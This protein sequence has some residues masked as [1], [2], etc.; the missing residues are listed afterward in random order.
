M[1]KLLSIAAMAMGLATPSLAQD[2]EIRFTLDWKLQGVHAWFYLA[3]EKGYFAEE[4]L[5]VT[6]DQGEGSAA[7]ITRI[8]SGAYD[9][10]F[11]DMNAIVQNA[12]VT[13]ELA[14]IMVY[15]IYNQPPF[16]ILVPADSP[17]EGAADLAGMTV[18]SPPGSAVT[19]LFPA[20]AA[21]AGLDLEEVDILSV[22]PNLQEQML[23]QGDVDASL[24]F[25][26]TSYLNLIGLGK[27]PD[28]EYRFIGYGD[29]GLDIYSNGVMVSRQLYEENPEAVAGLVRAINRAVMEIIADPA[30]GGATVKGVEPLIDEDLE[31]MRLNFA[32]ENLITSE[33]SLALGV[34]GVDMDRLARTIGIIQSVYEFETAPDASTIFTDEFLPP[35]EDRAL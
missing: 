30:L 5:S 7:T 26:V 33:E 22:Q 23:L 16:S 11:G 14:P 4:G 35:L 15:Q 12:A 31:T 28:T 29:A 34:G 25:N 20:L 10:G 8:M 32:L 2:T 13:P 24:V 19:K 18:G 21:Q 17:I 1:K 3:E 27:D 9:A 6:I